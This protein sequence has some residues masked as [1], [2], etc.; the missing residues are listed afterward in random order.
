LKFNFLLPQPGPPRPAGPP[1]PGQPYYAAPPGVPPT[2]HPPPVDQYGRPVAVSYPSDPYRTERRDP[3]APVLS[4]AEIEEALSKNKIVCSTAISNA[5][6][7]ASAGEFARSIE[8]LVTAISLI[9]QSKIANDDRCKILISSLQDT[10]KGIEDKSYGA[11]SSRSDRR[12]RSRSRSRDRD[13]DRDR[14][15]EREKRSRHR[16]RSREREYRERSREGRE[17]E[18]YSRDRYHDDRRRHS[19]RDREREREDYRRH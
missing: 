9:K 3:P 14:D 1:P 4:E 8:T 16:S 6:Q 17:R 7:D 13:R 18:A 5:V 11:K 19:E 15:R 2:S 12:S 10:L